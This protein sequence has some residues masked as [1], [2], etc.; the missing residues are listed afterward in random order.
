MFTDELAGNP[1]K[2]RADE[3]KARR[4]RAKRE[5]EAKDLRKRNE[6]DRQQREAATPAA[7]SCGENLAV[8]NDAGAASGIS[9]S[10][11]VSHVDGDDHSVTATQATPISE[12]L[13]AV[14]K[15]AEQ[16][17]LRSEARARVLAAT[18]I[19]SLV[20]CKLVAAKAR[21]GQRTIFD[22]RMSDLMT[23]SS[24]LKQSTKADSDC[25]SQ[26]SSQ[27]RNKAQFW[28]NGHGRK[29]SATMDETCQERAPAR[30]IQ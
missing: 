15:A 24:I 1:A 16:R 2:K 6:L 21:D 19:Q 8:S 9:S 29:R 22:T 14:Q 20:R 11:S 26:A 13:T 12:A 23:L 18:S 17:R 28:I 5:K 3:A 25:H 7:L 30:R 27:W 4:L 10:S